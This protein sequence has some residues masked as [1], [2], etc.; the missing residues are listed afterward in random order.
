M[1]AAESQLQHFKIT[2]E[3]SQWVALAADAIDQEEQ[4]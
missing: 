3:R 1:I 2:V 4:G